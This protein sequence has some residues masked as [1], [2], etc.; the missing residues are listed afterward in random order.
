MNE[1]YLFAGLPGAGKSTARKMGVSLVGGDSIHAGTMIRQMAAKDGLKNPSSSE[2]ADYA[3][4]RRETEGPAF[5]AERV[6]GL[7]HRGELDVY[8]P[9]FLDSVRHKQSVYEFREAF[10]NAFLIWVDA[11]FEARL[12]RL[13]D[14]GRDDEAGFSEEDLVDRDEFELDELGVSTIMHN[15]ELIDYRVQNDGSLGD[16]KSSMDAILHE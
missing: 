2:L 8:Y 10:G 11:P 16:L 9:L 1:V 5:F 15:E 3:A 7:L 12:E 14:R 4:E 6:N 13:R